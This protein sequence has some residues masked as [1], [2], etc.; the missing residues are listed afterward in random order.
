MVGWLRRHGKAI[1]VEPDPWGKPVFIRDGSDAGCADAEAV[2]YA[3]LDACAPLVSGA[4]GTIVERLGHESDA[5]LFRMAVA[6]L[7]LP[8]DFPPPV[9]AAADEF[10]DVDVEAALA[11]DCRRDLRSVPHVTIDGAD[12]RDFDDAVAAVREEDCYRVWVSIADVAWYVRPRSAI[13]KEALHRGTSV[14]LPS[15]VLPM[16]PE[17]LSNDLCS[18]RPGIPRLTVTCEM[19]IDEAGRR[20]EISVYPSLIESRAR[21]TYTQVRAALEGNPEAVPASSRQ[22]VQQ[23]AA[24]AV[25][26]RRHRF[27]RGSLD[28]H[29]PEAF[30]VMDPSGTPA[31]VDSCESDRAHHLIEDLMIAANESVAE[32]LL[33]HKLAGIYRVHPPPP[34]EKWQRLRAWSKRFGIPLKLSEVDRPK[35]VARFVEALRQTSQADAG[36]LLLLRALAQAYYDHRVGPHYG[37]ASNAYVHFTSPIRRYPD[38]LVQRA[39]WRHWR[40]KPRLRGLEQLAETASVAERRALEAEREITHLA[41]CMVASRRMGEELEAKVVGVHA[42][43]LFVRPNDLFA[44]G[45]LPFA[46]A[47][48]ILEE[49]FDIHEEE[50]IARGRRSGRQF[51]LGDTLTVRLAHVDLPLRRINFELTEGE[52]ASPGAPSA[53]GRQR[54]IEPVG[55]ERKRRGNRARPG[56]QRGRKKRRGR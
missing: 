43:G 38:L 52:S 24:A 34:R 29:I 26:L 16:L 27:A 5:T 56:R 49:G 13:D 41:A 51:A 33:D 46:S 30:V 36:Q 21:L 45:L 7:E 22:T 39:L 11:A 28:L 37:L 4:E 8:I 10:P 17:R 40:G 12:A 42:A 23:A 3:F 25:L 15:R 35:T 55:T 48:R 6:A 54:S 47:S 53:A 31:R 9:L 18:L 2:R 20:H 50:Q 44:E 19:V 1:W 32:F 14:Y